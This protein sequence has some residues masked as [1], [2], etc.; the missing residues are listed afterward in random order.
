MSLFCP[1][2]WAQAKCLDSR[3]NPRTNHVRRRHQ[4]QDE[5]CKHKFTTVEV[6]VGAVDLREHSDNSSLLAIAWEIF[7]QLGGDQA[8]KEFFAAWVERQQ[9][10]TASRRKAPAKANARAPAKQKEDHPWRRMKSLPEGAANA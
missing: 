2:C 5:G 1:V 9:L 8:E 3:C 10:A 7:D 6:I 4:C